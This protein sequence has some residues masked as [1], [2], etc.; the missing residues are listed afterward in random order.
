MVC[1]LLGMG[2]ISYWRQL[3][4][5]HSRENGE[6]SFFC[7]FLLSLDLDSILIL[8]VYSYT[9]PLYMLGLWLTVGLTLCRN[10][11]FN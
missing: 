6:H 10:I 9:L 4:S 3:N 11:T 2:G 8:L 7:A 5:L 1:E